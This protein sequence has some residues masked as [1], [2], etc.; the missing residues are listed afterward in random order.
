MGQTAPSAARMLQKHRNLGR[1]KPRA[2][3]SA[4]D[5]HCDQFQAVSSSGC[6]PSFW[7]GPLP[8]NKHLQCAPKVLVGVFGGQQP[9][10]G[11]VRGQLLF[12]TARHRTNRLTGLSAARAE[13]RRRIPRAS[14]PS[15][16]HSK[17]CK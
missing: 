13:L 15:H 7:G 12:G 3:L 5:Q 2:L 6:L 10:P 14:M 16:R 11:E 8:L 1:H 9:T 17:Q 4:A